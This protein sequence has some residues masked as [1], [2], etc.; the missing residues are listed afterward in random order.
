MNCNNLSEN[1]KP[2][3]GMRAIWEEHKIPI[4]VSTVAVLAII[5]YGKFGR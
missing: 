3:E 4:N 5:L 2:P 1:S